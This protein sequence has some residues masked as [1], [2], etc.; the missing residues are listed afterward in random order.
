MNIFKN[1][2]KKPRQNPMI[3]RK[4]FKIKIVE[5]PIDWVDVKDEDYKSHPFFSQLADVIGFNGS[6]YLEFYL[7][8]DAVNLFVCFEELKLKQLLA[9]FTKFFEF[10]IEDITESVI[11]G[12][13]Q[14]LYPESS[15]FLTNFR[16]KN[17]P[18]DS[19]LDKINKT[20][21]DSLDEIDKGILKGYSSFRCSIDDI[22]KW[23]DENLVYYDPIFH[24]WNY[25]IEDAINDML[26]RFKEHFFK[27][28]LDETF[29][30]EEE[31]IEYFRSEWYSYFK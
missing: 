5:E 28:D 22:K 7:E 23:V 10:T 13:M 21:I 4:I 6:K 20:G 1:N 14:K 9:V 17:T 16:L 27:I 24:E 11:N 8:G 29:D 26:R 2:I 3:L 30:N 15:R 18:I 31:L 12:E 19:I 25:T